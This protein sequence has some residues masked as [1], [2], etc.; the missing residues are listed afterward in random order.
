M[1]IRE[2]IHPAQYALEMSESELKAIVFVL[3]QARA[4]R[5]DKNITGYTDLADSLIN[6]LDPDQDSCE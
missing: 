6:D 2:I 5:K 4:A 1:T 3:R